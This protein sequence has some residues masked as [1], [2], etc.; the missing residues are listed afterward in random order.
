[1]RKIVAT[2]A[3]IVLAT[4]FAAAQDLASVTELFNTAATSLNDGNKAAAFE[5]FNNALTQATALGEEGAEIVANCKD[6]LPKLVVSIAKDLV[7]DS[8]LDGAIAKLGEAI[9]LAKNYNSEEALADAQE[10]L[11]QVKKQKGANF[12]KDKDYAAAAEVFKAI[13][14]DD[15]A[16][17]VS[18]LRLGQSLNALGKADEAIA[19]FETAAANGQEANANKQIGN[20]YLKKA[21]AALKTKNY[22]DAVTAA[23]KTTEYG[24]NAQA[25]Q[26]AGQ[27]SQLAGKNNDAIKYFEKYLEASPNA[28]NAGQIAYTLGALYQQNKNIAK[29]KEFYTKASTDPKYGAEAKKLLDALK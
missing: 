10:L 9:E 20:V 12:L 26:I 2:I 21:A 19:A 28:K 6:L 3:A 13:L 17:G 5:Q 25:W 29:A 4:G 15:P 22:N 14:A 23:V 27:A 1:M 24:D 18:A 7:K 8:D 16:D 11:P